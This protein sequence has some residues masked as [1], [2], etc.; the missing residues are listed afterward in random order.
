MTAEGNIKVSH[1]II[2]IQRS[3]DGL[4]GM[5]I[6]PSPLANESDQTKYVY[7]LSL[8]KSER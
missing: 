3:V 8:R 6:S 2:I 4:N 5:N 7:Y 1:S